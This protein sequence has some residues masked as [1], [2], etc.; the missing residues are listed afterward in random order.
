MFL[1]TILTSPPAAN[2]RQRSCW[3]TRQSILI[4]DCLKNVSLVFLAAVLEIETY[5]KIANDPLD[6]FR[7]GGGG[8]W[9]LLCLAS[10]KPS[11]PIYILVPGSA[12]GI[13]GG[14]WTRKWSSVNTEQLSGWLLSL[15]ALS[16]APSHRP[17]HHPGTAHLYAGETLL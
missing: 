6:V 10:R 15:K 13:P 2:G 3:R 11:A 7:G 8:W 4:P 14:R 12:A 1:P 9:L 16:I 17:T 5:Q